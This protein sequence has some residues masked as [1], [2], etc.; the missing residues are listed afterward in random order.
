MK[1]FDE[2]KNI[3]YFKH[4]DEDRLQLLYSISKKRVFSKNEILF[5]EKDKPKNLLYF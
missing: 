3:S 2:L 1:N 4:L 5:Y